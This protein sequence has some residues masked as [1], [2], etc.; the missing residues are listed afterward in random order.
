[1]KYLEVNPWTRQKFKGRLFACNIYW[2]QFKK[3]KTK[4]KKKEK[5]SKILFSIPAAQNMEGKLKT[6]M[7]E[8]FNYKIFCLH[9]MC[10]S[11]CFQN[12]GD[13]ENS[14]GKLLRKFNIFLR[15]FIFVSESWRN[16]F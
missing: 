10:F 12:A 9:S 8:T 14:L 5:E 6:D 16:I 1:M 15:I 7:P 4:K 13:N 2:T 3:K 11:S